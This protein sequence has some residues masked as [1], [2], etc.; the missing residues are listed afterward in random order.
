MSDREL[1]AL[2]RAAGQRPE[3]P[4]E[5]GERIRDA[6]R[7]HWLAL[8]AARVRRRRIRLVGALAA[9]TLAVALLGIG[10]RRLT[11][12]P[13]VPPE[14]APPAIAV[15]RVEAMTGE[16]RAIAT[17]PVA[18]G[19]AV[20]SGSDWETGG[21]AHLVLRL[22]TGH[23]VRLDEQSRLR[24]LGRDR[25]DLHHGAVY[26][27]SGGAERPADAPIEIRTPRGTVREAGTQYE[28]RVDGEAVRVRVR[29]G[30][31]EVSHAAGTLNVSI[32]QEL[33]VDPTGRVARG[34]C[35]VYGPDWSW[36]ERAAPLP[37]IEGL[38]LDKVL[39][40]M[41]RERGLRLV[42]APGTPAAAEIRLAGSIRGMTLDEA[43]IAV[44]AT[45]G[46]S[47]TVENG[48]L[49]LGP[50]GMETPGPLMRRC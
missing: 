37:D 10:L 31:V 45:S 19:E 6:T 15:G 17:R 35:A 24:V 16:V 23:S 5:R 25:L 46:M 32:G 50:T 44:L 11:V 30:A 3:P 48:V 12:P 2:L 39:R 34:A 47:H 42:Y 13:A 18:I 21:G 4:A 22:S 40:W 14:N 8:R 20:T 29:E 28:V 7:A 38:S 33:R 41:A 36:A 27:D 1:E 9:G 43:L 49:K 26:L